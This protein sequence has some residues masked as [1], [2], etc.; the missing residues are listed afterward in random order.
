MWFFPWP[1]AI[2][3]K[4]GTRL[5]KAAR[6]VRAVD[7]PTLIELFLEAAALP[8]GPKSTA[9]E[10]LQEH[11]APEG[12]HYLIPR[13]RWPWDGDHSQLS[14]EIWPAC[15]LLRMNNGDLVCGRALLLKSRFLALPQTL[16]S[17]Q[18]YRIARL[19]GSTNRDIHLWRLD[20]RHD[21]ACEFPSC[22]EERHGHCD[23]PDRV[24]AGKRA[25][26]HR[27]K[28]RGGR[29]AQDAV[30]HLMALGFMEIR[31]TSHVIRREVQAGEGSGSLDHLAR[32]RMIADICHNLPGDLR[33]VSRG[34]R[35]RRAIESLRFHLRELE[36]DDQAAQWVRARLDEL[37]Y[38][39]VPLLP[40]RAK[41]QRT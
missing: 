38:D 36:P 11:L 2:D 3:R 14:E 29:S 27:S 21:P 19:A 24:E 41:W 23:C 17:R 4:Y 9:A 20:H 12:D 40:D 8:G 26:R 39:Y 28:I 37:G 25:K 1:T 32:V 13:P 18:Q 15:E 35:E 31:A 6:T 30:R 16:S 34:E 5:P 33:P 7:T 22:I 10:F